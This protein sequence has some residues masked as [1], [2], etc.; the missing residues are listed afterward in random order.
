MALG[1]SFYS[2]AFSPAKRTS[3]IDNSDYELND[4]FKPTGSTAQPERS[5]TGG[6][7]APE[8]GAGNNPFAPPGHPSSVATPGAGT[9]QPGV[10]NDPYAPMMKHLTDASQRLE[11]AF[12][13]PHS[14]TARQIFGALLSRRNPGLGGLVSGETQRNRSIEQAQEDYGIA[15]GQL[16]AARTQQN[17]LVENNL[18]TAQTQKASADADYATKHASV[19]ENPPPKATPE[20][21]AMQ[22]YIKQ[23]KTPAQAYAQVQQDKQD[24][25][26]DKTIG[27]PSEED[28]ALGDYL[29]GHNLPDTPA[30]RDRARSVLKTRDK[31]AKDPD[32]ADINMQL[33]KAALEKLKEPTPD[34]QRR[35]DLST[36]AEENLG[37]LEDILKRRPE[38]F[39]PLA[40]R[41]TQLRGAVGTN[42]TDVAKLKAIHEFYGMASVGAHAMRNAQHV[43]TAADA[44]M[45]GF[46]NGPEGM[47]GAIDTARSSFK[48]FHENAG[49][50][51]AAIDNAT[52]GGG[53]T[54][55]PAVNP[56][57]PLGIL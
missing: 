56:K 33:K 30:N 27:K 34:E 25:K 6:A 13:A 57:D 16:T 37:Q 51:R 1:D 9:S 23:G 40:G 50:R 18:K 24:T 32:L 39:G 38:L 11:S 26:P 48:T 44:I 55:A 54:P 4:A 3:P 31:P 35:D 15:A 28:K 12:S 20:E 2:G 52:G 46:T 43:S 41:L 42:D 7:T 17:Q 45:N 47:K 21:M 14:G 29:Q 36:N 5:L 8:P 53:A 22:D 49:R 10:V 19:I